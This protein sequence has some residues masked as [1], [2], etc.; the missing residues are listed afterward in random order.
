MPLDRTDSWNSECNIIAYS[1]E[2]FGNFFENDEYSTDI[3]VKDVLDIVQLSRDEL[4]G[5]EARVRLDALL[6]GMLLHAPNSN[7]ARY[8]AICLYLA[9]QRNTVVDIVKAWLDHLF[10]LII[11][12]VA[13]R[14]GHRCAITHL[15]EESMEAA[16]I[17]PYS[18]NQFTE[19]SGP[20]LRDSARTWDM[21][22]HWT[23]LDIKSL[24]G[25]K[26]NTPA[27]VIYMTH[28]EHFDFGRFKLSLEPV[29]LALFSITCRRPC[30]LS[31]HG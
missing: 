13:A 23:T 16:H 28:D 3:L 19:S 22:H 26:I 18:L 15:I 21:L 2:D 6:R 11:F 5:A 7:G 8:I 20:E 27:N 4:R 12:S 24:V 14:E 10:L 29:S 31:G 30:S 17:I 1:T 25:E 9:H